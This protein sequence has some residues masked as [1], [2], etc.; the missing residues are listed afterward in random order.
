MY[1]LNGFHH[2]KK[3]CFLTLL[4]IFST[5]MQ[6]QSSD[7]STPPGA[8]AAPASSAAVNERQNAHYFPRWPERRHEK[9]ERLPP[10]PPG[11]YMSSAL[12]LDGSAV[13]NSPFSRDTSPAKAPAQ[14]TVSKSTFSP[15]TP[16]PSNSH[17][18][19]R[20]KPEAG[21]HYV[22]PQA[23]NQPYPAIPSNYQYGYRY[24][25]MNRSAAVRQRVSGADGQHQ[26]AY[27]Y[28]RQAEG[29]TVMQHRQA[30][31]NMTYPAYSNP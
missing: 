4:M 26:D 15:D 8:E 30:T 16:W 17:S 24:P 3:A 27:R 13:S 19:H 18:P 1:L 12:A 5:N 6:A 23:K 20:W 14:P 11:P 7:D 29:N 9:R 31:N 10:P 25:V 28:N 22:Q 2:F 21:Y